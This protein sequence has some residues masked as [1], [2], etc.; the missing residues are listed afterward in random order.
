MNTETRCVTALS[1]DLRQP[2]AEVVPSQLET[3]V[4]SHWQ[5]R[6]Q[7]TVRRT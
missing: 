2:L 4:P 7:G 3:H 6:S 5:S 1:C